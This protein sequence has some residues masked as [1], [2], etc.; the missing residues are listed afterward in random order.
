[1]RSTTGLYPWTA[2]IF[3]YINDLPVCLSE[4]IPNMYADDTNIT[5]YHTN[6]NK[7]EHVLLNKDLDILYRWLQA[8][9]LSL[10]VLKSE[11][12]LIGSKV[13]INKLTSDLKIFIGGHRLIKASSCNKIPGAYD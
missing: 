12:M 4:S 9:R 2:V 11:Y 8:N 10:N 13:R 6:I 1:M 3:I 7:V 5:A